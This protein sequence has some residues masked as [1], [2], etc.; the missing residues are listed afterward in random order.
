QKQQAAA[1]AQT[2]RR[3]QP[4]P[5]A[6]KEEPKSNVKYDSVTLEVFNS[7]GELIRTLKQK[8]PDKNGLH[9]MYW[10]LDEKG[11][12]WLSR[13]APR[14]RFEP[15]GVNVMPGTYKLRI[16]FGDQKDSTNINVRFDPRMDVSTQVL[17]ARYNMLK[18]VDKRQSLAAN[19]MDRLRDSKTIVEEYEKRLRDQ[20]ADEYKAFKD[21]NK[22]MKDSINKF[23]DEFVGKEDNR[24]GIIRSPEPN[25]NT[26]LG[27]ARRYIGGSFDMPGP[28]QQRAMQQLDA[29]LNPVI[30]RLNNFYNQ[31]WVEYRKKMETL[32]VSIFKDY[33]AL[34]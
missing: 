6:Q 10:N 3:G 26:M 22:V 18:E 8:A 16:S 25:V 30:N 14:G 28:T 2:G 29:H 33:Q 11:E 23:M 15:G 7:R 13:Q 12:R 20:S 24:Q 9:R 32:N 31:Q 17:Q 1:P 34:R 4:A 19:A 27:N 5:A 21:M